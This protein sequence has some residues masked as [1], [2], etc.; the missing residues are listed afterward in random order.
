MTR[1]D[2]YEFFKDDKDLL[3]YFDPNSNAKNNKEA[4]DEI[5]DKLVEF[6]CQWN[7]FFK[8]NKMGYIFYKNGLL[9]SFCVKP[10]Y[11]SKKNLNK[12]SNLIRSELG[13]SFSCYLYSVNTRAI[14]FLE[15]MGLK[16][17][18]SNNLITLLSI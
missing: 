14:S 9:L 8:K 2:I 1:E 18:E 10:K 17:I 7:C 16:K 3:K 12:F 5:Y 15:K 11:R 13:N 6:S 4:S